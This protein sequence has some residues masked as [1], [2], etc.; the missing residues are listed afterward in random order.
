MDP[1]AKNRLIS[2]LK[3]DITNLPRGLRLAAKYIIDY[4]AEFGLDPIRTTAD[5]AGVSTNTL[6]RLANRQ[7]FDSFEDMRAPFRHALVSTKAGI[8]TPDWVDTLAAHSDLGKVQ[9]DAAHNTL[10][11]VERS[12]ERQIPEQIQRVIQ[13]LLSAD[14]VFVTGARA[15]YG[16]AYYLQYV[17]K[18]ALPSMELIPRMMNSAIDDLH[19]ATE[20]DVLIAITFTPY[21]RETIEACQFAKQRGVRLVLISDSEIVSPDFAIDELL[22][23]SIQSSHHFACY[24]GVTA[25]VET[26][27]ALL[28]DQGGAEARA[29]INAYE[30]VRSETQMYWAAQKKR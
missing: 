21:S 6:V 25:L 15:S 17:G 29:R 26:I 8:E 28:V 5:K 12:L 23:A 14:R 1:R 30:T 7:G 24:A 27:V 9:A 16:M 20:G 3:S 4:P 18:M 22:V 19:T 11:I 13:M 10:A 2:D